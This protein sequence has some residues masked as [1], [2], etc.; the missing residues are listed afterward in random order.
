VTVGR[1]QFIIDTLVINKA[2]QVSCCHRAKLYRDV[3]AG[4]LS[5]N[6]PKQLVV[7]AGLVSFREW[8]EKKQSYIPKE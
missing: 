5:K 2:E 6:P 8:L 3:P 7:F 1:T 4:V